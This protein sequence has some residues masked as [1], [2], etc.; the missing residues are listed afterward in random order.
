MTRSSLKP[1]YEKFLK[2][3]EGWIHLAAHSHHF[4]PD[5]SRQAQ[6][7]YWD[8]CATL[9]DRKWEK[10]FGEVIPEAQRQIARM[11]KLKDPGN[12]VFA[13]NTHEL[14]SRVLS[15]FLGKKSLR[16][17][18]TTGEFHSWSRQL[19]RLEELPGVEVIRID[20]GL[21]HTDRTRF[22]HELKAAVSKDADLFYLSQVYFDSGNALS[23]EELSTLAEAKPKECLMLIDGYHGFCA[24]P[25]DLSALEGKIYYLA[26]GYKY[27][28]AGEG[29][30]FMVT[31]GTAARPAYTGWFAQMGS[32]SQKGAELIGYPAGAGAFWGSTQDFSGL[33][34]FNAVWRQFEALGWGIQEI[35]E[36]IRSLQKLFL[37]KLP[38]ET[39]K[40]WKSEAL[41]SST[42]LNQGH[43]L[44]FRLPDADR[45]Q[46]VHDALKAKKILVDYR[47][48]R[49]RFGFG[50]YLDEEDV[51][52]AAKRISG[53]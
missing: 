20:S 4:W 42:L 51:H 3:H 11:L 35:H 17:V 10:V 45:T 27:A 29:A 38:E 26:G 13:P 18:T 53:K 19:R 50:L 22:L 52:D 5:V 8:D 31:P 21:L 25:T 9:S 40:S 14:A 41:F 48:D 1:L 2:G 16:V 15:C 36:K 44:T 46:E 24:L 49:L 12:I 34:R 30:C 23:M 6:L 32:L 33:Y 47:G 37:E 28:Q 7:S 39:L 43:F